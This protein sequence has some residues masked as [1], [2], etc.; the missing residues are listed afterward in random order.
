MLVSTILFSFA[1]LNWTDLKT[2]LAV[3]ETWNNSPSPVNRNLYSI[4][5]NSSSN[6]YAAGDG[7]MLRYNGTGWEVVQG[8][9]YNYRAL[10]GSN[11]SEVVATGLGGPLEKFT[12][13][14]SGGEWEVNPSWTSGNKYG[15]WGSSAG[16]YVAVGDS[17]AKSPTSASTPIMRMTNG[18][19]SQ[20]PGTNAI[21]DQGWVYNTTLNAVWGASANSV[22]AGGM[23]DS[24][25]GPVIYH[26]DNNT[27]HA[28][29]ISTD[30]S[31]P[32]VG[33]WGA[34]ATDVWAVAGDKNK[35]GVQSR[36][37]I[38][39]YNGSAWTK[40]A[41]YTLNANGAIGQ[42][43]TSIW[44]TGG[45]DI[46]IVGEN[47]QGSSFMHYN[48]TAWSQVTGPAQNA[49]VTYRAI[50]GSGSGDVWAVGDGGNIAHFSN[51]VYNGSGPLTGSSTC[52]GGDGSAVEPSVQVTL[53]A[54]Q[55][56]RPGGTV[57]LS[58]RTT[59]AE[60]VTVDG[61][62][63]TPATSGSRQYWINANHTFIVRA[64]DSQ[65][66][67]CAENQSTVNVTE[68]MQVS[69]AASP[70]TAILPSGTTT[71]TA[72]VNS[73]ITGTFTYT[74]YC[75]RND[76]GTDVTEGW[77]A[78]YT[79]E[80]GSTKQTA[81]CPYNTVGNF[82]AK[83]IV[84]QTGVAPAEARVSVVRVNPTLYVSLT[85][86][87]TSGTTPF[88]PTFTAS[89]SGTATGTINY[90]FYCNRSDNGTN[91][92]S[93]YATKKDGV[94][95]ETQTSTD[96]NYTGAGTYRAKVIVERGGTAAQ[97]QLVITATTITMLAVS[98]LALTPN[99]GLEPI[100]NVVLKAV[101]SGAATG[102]INYYFWC[103][104]SDGNTTITSD[105]DY[106]VM[107]T[108]QT[109]VTTPALCNYTG[110]TTRYA[111]VIVERQ[112]FRAQRQTGITP[113]SRD[114]NA[115]LTATPN[116]GTLTL[117]STIRAT[118]GGEGTGT[119]NYTFYCNRSDTGTN[120]TPGYNFKIDGVSA[121]TYNVTCNYNA[122]GSYTA[123]VIVE[124]G[125]AA[126][127]QA[128]VSVTVSN[129]TLSVNSFSA[130]IATGQAPQNPALTARVG[131]TATGSMNYTFYCHRSDNGTNITPGYEYKI[132][133]TNL[134]QVSTSVCNYTI[135]G[136]YNPKVIIERGGL[137]AQAL[138]TVTYGNS[139]PQP[140]SLSLRINNSSTGL[141]V[142]LGSVLNFTWTSSYVSQLVS[143]SSNWQLPET[144]PLNCPTNCG[145]TGVA[146]QLGDQVYWLE[147]IGPLGIVRKEV[148]VKVVPPAISADQVDYNYSRGN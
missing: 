112:G 90:T 75:N 22:W 81:V 55:I 43:P 124:R 51:S 119:I 2:V 19:W 39:H 38:Y 79:Y 76:S 72:T 17:W 127:Q 113:T 144:A 89:V 115:T 20:T 8:R 48:G 78:R 40:Q 7:I 73:T 83:V 31:A 88:R 41:G 109:T 61:I 30:G 49:N 87:A 100:N 35:G 70:A 4:W 63:V 74:F 46:W 120:I 34:S 92:T 98:S 121:T 141:I 94:S 64:C 52:S 27:W 135:G 91:I 47:S 23:N 99:S 132:D 137:A 53:S 59:G 146:E 15:V 13:S 28:D 104:R 68:S 66:E 105:Y 3:G 93:G 148:S 97:A 130:N 25:N 123:K 126:P 10:S 114:L 82:T 44:G 56:A 18:V 103:S 128:R 139:I 9:C 140:P 42:L 147:A 11:S 67:N 102:R 110:T 122:V 5:G 71:L 134:T 14:T 36:R 16:N 32:I 143:T 24:R 106:Q 12:S 45:S 118:V 37:D 145:V 1:W 101:I 69:L 96:C 95:A 84:E 26:W 108:E 29:M 57:L 117:A 58:W 33:I 125:T 54:Q 80:T 60:K 111:K 50:W 6:I 133:G 138:T 136:T 65:N 86:S 21:L 116:S 77:D 62:Q 107:D 142:Q 85:S 131:G 129:P